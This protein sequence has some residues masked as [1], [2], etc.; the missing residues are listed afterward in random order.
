MPYRIVTTG[1]GSVREDLRLDE[2]LVNPELA[3]GDFGR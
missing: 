1:R 3:K 2:I